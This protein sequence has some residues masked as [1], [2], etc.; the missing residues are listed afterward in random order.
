MP[1][2]PTLLFIAGKGRSGSTFLGHVLGQVPRP[3]ELPFVDERT[4]ELGPT[5][6]ITG[7]P[8]RLRTGPIAVRLDDRWRREMTA[9]DRSLVTALTWPLLARYGY[10]MRPANQ[11]SNVQR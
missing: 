3:I 8:D 7:N 10:L 5:H 4:V 1:S 6:S 11:A 2:A 9:R